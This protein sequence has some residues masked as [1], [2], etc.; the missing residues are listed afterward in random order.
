MRTGPD[1]RTSVCRIERGL[2][3]LRYVEAATS[4]C[5]TAKVTILAG[6]MRF[7]SAPG[8]D[9]DS[10]AAPGHTLVIYAEAPSEFEIQVVGAKGNGPDARTA[11]KFSIDMLDAGEAYG[12]RREPSPNH[13][14]G[15]DV[16]GRGSPENR[17][18]SRNAGD[19]SVT[20][21]VSRRGDVLVGD[22]EWVAGP[23]VVL[24]IEGLSIATGRPDLGVR[25]RVQ[26]ARS[27]HRWSPWHDPEEF[28]GSRQQ[29]DCLTAIA[30]ALTGDAADRFEIVADVM[31]LGMP[32]VA[33]RGHMIEFFGVDPIVGF[34]F[35]LQHARRDFDAK[36]TPGPSPLRV[37]RA[38]R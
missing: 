27:G 13:H 11:A 24:P 19:V 14:R 35:A 16:H 36:A 26:S 10:L 3:A 34:R 15:I 31:A 7:V 32:P 18:E 22:D 9:R 20:A 4:P 25:I 29:A 6:D 8:R 17:R 21:H 30:L 28:A 1:S 37:F 12:G 2:Y 23:D 38:K 33:K 5:A